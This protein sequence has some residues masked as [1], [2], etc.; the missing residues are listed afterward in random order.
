MARA[1]LTALAFGATLALSAQ[2]LDLKQ[3]TDAEREAIHAKDPA[4]SV[5]E[6]KPREIKNPLV[7]ENVEEIFND[8]YS[9]VGGNPG[10]DITLVEFMDYRCGYC[11]KAY[12]EVAELIERDGNIR[13][14]IKE[15]PILGPES[16]T[17]SKF[18]LATQRVVGNE[19]Y[20]AVHEAL[21][22][23]E[24]PTHNPGLIKLLESLGFDSTGVLDEMNNPEFKEIAN[25]NLELAYRLEITGT[26]AFVMEDQILG[27]YMPV[28]E[29]EEVVQ[30]I[31]AR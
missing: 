14:I 11:R 8:G 13:L 20:A 16:V 7:A 6:P 3:S 27:G 2:A 23:Y 15:L 31:R 12:P 17:L 21:M 30:A 29:M 5:V 10:G 4:T 1:F 28:E 22:G 19:A 18:A 26:P 9:W 25:R 24:G